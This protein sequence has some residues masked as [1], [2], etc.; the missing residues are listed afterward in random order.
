M[1]LIIKSRENQTHWS[2]EWKNVSFSWFL[3]KWTGSLARRRDAKKTQSIK[4]RINFMHWERGQK[5][6]CCQGK[7]AKKVSDDDGSCSKHSE[8]LLVYADKK[9]CCCARVAAQT[10]DPSWELIPRE[11]EKITVEEKPENCLSKYWPQSRLL[12]LAI[13]KDGVWGT[14]NFIYGRTI[15]PFVL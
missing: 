6:C 12:S 4:E 15:E 10:W 2:F 11:M 5:C 7:K 1:G 8:I 3:R 9:L 13:F 14:L